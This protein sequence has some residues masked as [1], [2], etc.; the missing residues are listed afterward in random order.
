M[1]DPIPG[2]E[3]TDERAGALYRPLGAYAAL[4][5][6]FLAGFGAVLAVAEAREPAA[7]DHDARAIARAHG[8]RSMSRSAGRPARVC[9]S[10]VS[11]VGP[12][13]SDPAVSVTAPG[14][15]AVARRFTRPGAG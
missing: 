10:I 1:T 3:V 15:A 9:I 4:T 6:A 14:G 12:V 7:E 13:L 8:A 11:P 5:G 2:T